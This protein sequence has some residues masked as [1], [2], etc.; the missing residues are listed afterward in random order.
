MNNRL[1]I[2][3]LSGTNGSGKDTLGQLL[4]K[5]YG[6][7]FVSVTELLRAELHRRE[8]PITRKNLRMI[9]A[10]W[11][12]ELGLGVLIDKAVADY[13]ASKENYAGVVISSLRNP[14]EA[15]RVHDL[16]GSVVWIDADPKIRYA[17]I[18]ANMDGRGRAEEDNKTFEQFQAEE[19]DEMTKPEGGD[20]ATLSMGAVKA[21]ADIT[22]DNGD[23]DI[24]TFKA[25]VER[26][27]GL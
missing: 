26:A 23:Q 13:K 4:A 12:R 21:L 17:R 24:P 7:M 9:S 1:Q 25:E 22:I 27:L 16:G 15:D 3:G 10:E 6:F 5:D 8:L 19:A 11:R 20:T 18:Q 2:I 14:G